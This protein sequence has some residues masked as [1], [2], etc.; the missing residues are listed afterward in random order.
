MRRFFLKAVA[1]T[2]CSGG[3]LFAASGAHANVYNSSVTGGSAV[4]TEATGALTVALTS[5]ITNP[6]SAG[7]EISGIEITFSNSVGTYTSL[8]QSGQLINFGTGG[9][10]I[11][12][13]GNPTHWA[14]G[15]PSS[16]DVILDTVDIDTGSYLS[17]THPGATPKDL[18][19]G[20]PNGSGKYSNANS[21]IT[22][23]H[24]PSIQET[25]TFVIDLSNLQSNDVIDSVEYFFGTTSPV[26]YFFGTTSPGGDSS[27]VDCSPTLVTTGGGSQTAV[28]EP[29]SLALLAVGILGL[30]FVRRRQA[31]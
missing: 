12:V 4:I 14:A 9:T 29:A 7:Q 16:H 30:F 6:T 5:T 18:I 17:G 19:I 28:P 27:L 11:D 10:P 31:I 21:S 3:L 15:V 2:T 20:D 8:S 1:A 24:A 13:S 22:G 26:E 23:V 25:G